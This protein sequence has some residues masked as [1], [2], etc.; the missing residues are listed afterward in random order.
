M[1]DITNLYVSEFY[2]MKVIC[3]TSQSL[4]T[5]VVTKPLS[6]SLGLHWER[7]R[8][9][10]NSYPLF[11]PVVLKGSDILTPVPSDGDKLYTGISISPGSMYLCIPLSQVALWILS[12]SENKTSSAVRDN[13][14]RC[15]S[16]ISKDLRGFH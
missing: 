9:R 11:T 12:I 8:E 15:K 7:Q 14:L 10:L 6:D 4:G 3:V 2:G 13:L 5:L 1:S 16:L